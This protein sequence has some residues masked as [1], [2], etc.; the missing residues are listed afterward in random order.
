M[1][2]LYGFVPRLSVKS[3]FALSA[4]FGCIVWVLTSESHAELKAVASTTQSAS[5]DFPHV[6][7]FEQGATRFADGDRIAITEI[8]GTAETFSR[9]NIY[10]IKGTYT[11]G[12]HD[13][14]TLAAYITATEAKNNFGHTLK[15]QHLKIDRGEG[16]FTL[17]LPMYSDGLPHVSFYSESD[18]NGFGGNYFG[19]GD[20]VL[21]E[22]WGTKK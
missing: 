4:A 10:L 15:V 21:K 19:T 7:K 17:F 18:G 8:R 12:S 13:R 9:G 5:S 6:V 11:L 22:W 1:A 3:A 16:T 20:S 2:L 14:A